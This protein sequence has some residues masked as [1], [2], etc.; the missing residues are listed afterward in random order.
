MMLWAVLCV[1]LLFLSG[2]AGGLFGNEMPDCRTTKAVFDDPDNSDR[3]ITGRVRACQTKSS[4]DWYV[5]P[6]FE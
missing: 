6:R 2:C 4:S 5:S 3:K 1:G